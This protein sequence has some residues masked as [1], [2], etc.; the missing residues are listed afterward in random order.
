MMNQQSNQPDATQPRMFDLNRPRG[1][2]KDD[3]LYMW[4]LAN[5]SIFELIRNNRNQPNNSDIV[6]AVM[7]AI[8]L[9]AHDNIRRKEE[10]LFS[11]ALNTIK[12]FNGVPEEELVKLVIAAINDNSMSAEQ[13]AKNIIRMA[14]TSTMTAND[15]LEETMRVCSITMGNLTSYVDQFRGLAHTLKVG[16]LYNFDKPYAQ[17]KNA[18]PDTESGIINV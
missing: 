12:Y 4:S 18:F 16:E 15:K 2:A 1:F 7:M 3:Y 6:H 13:R 5:N 9:I 8:S 17:V 14:R 10:I 11:E